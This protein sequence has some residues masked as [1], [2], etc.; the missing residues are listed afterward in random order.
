MTL[1]GQQIRLIGTSQKGKNRI[2][3]H[4]DRWTVIAETDRILFDPSKAGPWIFVTPK[5][6]GPGLGQ[7]DKASRWIHANS[8][9]DFRV[10]PMDG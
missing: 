9:F 1:L 5:V 3:E 10:M 7:D 4:G 2:R 6:A 8:D